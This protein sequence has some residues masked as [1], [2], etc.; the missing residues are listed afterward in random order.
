VKILLFLLLFETVLILFFVFQA[1]LTVF[2]AVALITVILYIYFKII[3]WRKQR[4]K[5][6]GV[7]A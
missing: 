1:F 4:K 7:S 3:S 2:G 6:K 5:P